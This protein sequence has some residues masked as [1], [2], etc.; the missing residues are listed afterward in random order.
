MASIDDAVNALLAADR[1]VLVLDTCMLLDIIRS[2][3]R[4]L[5]NYT[6]RGLELSRLASSTPPGCTIVVS[7]IV[8]QEWSD[9]AQAV[10]EET[11]RHLRK[12]E[13]QSSHF[14]DACQALGIAVASPRTQYGQSRLAEALQDLSQSLIDGAVRLDADADSH[15]RAVAR[16][17]NRTPPALRREVKDSAIIEEYLAV[18]R[19]LQAAGFARKQIFCTSNTEDYCTAGGR[20]HVN[21][22]AEFAAFTLTFTTSLPWALHEMRR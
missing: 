5:S 19:G 6:E 8:P 3:H 7:S 1:P 11:A 16:V 14:H 22:A 21:L 12:M 13:E 20:L 9:N 17:V 15:V 2:T 4:C 18:C 10:V